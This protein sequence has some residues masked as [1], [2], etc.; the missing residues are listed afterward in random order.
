VDL[1][2]TGAA[3][4]KGLY[5]NDLTNGNRWLEVNLVGTMSNRSAIG[6]RIHVLA[7]IGGR[8]VWQIREVSAQNSFNGHSEFT[9]HVGLGDAGEVRELRVVWPHGLEER[10]ENVPVNTVLTLV[11][12]ES[13]PTPTAVALVASS[14]TERG[15]QLTWSGHGL[16]S[17]TVV[18]RR[19][20]VGVWTAIGTPSPVGSDLV[21]FVDASAGPGRWAYR[22]RLPDAE[23]AGEAWV[24][25]PARA[26]RVRAAGVDAA[27]GRLGVEFEL[28]HAGP[29]RIRVVDVAGRSVAT[30]DLGLL[31]A[32][33]GR[34]ELEG[35]PF[36][37]GIYWV[38]LTHD[39]RSI[40]ARAIL[41]R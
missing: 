5:R 15:V 16:G 1:Y 27:G 40:A 3:G 10:L 33:S 9:L 30:R 6:A 19:P 7:T 24:V 23:I 37:P 31:P 41:L 22:L 8:D 21:S 34:V 38:R 11:E 18:E 4:L 35:P 32:G 28:P 26:L 2:V 25:V 20:E 17:G 12:G 13:T 29:A 39:G 14:V 36:A